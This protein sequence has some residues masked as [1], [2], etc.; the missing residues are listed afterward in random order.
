MKLIDKVRDFKQENDE[1]NNTC[2]LLWTKNLVTHF[3]A[4]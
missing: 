4:V 3:A 2:S 1:I